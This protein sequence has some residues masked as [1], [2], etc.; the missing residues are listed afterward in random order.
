MALF[1]TAFCPPVEYFAIAAEY[2]CVSIEACEY[3]EKQTYRNRCRILTA[4]G[5]ESF[6]PPVIHGEDLYRTPVRDVRVDYSVDWVGRFEYALESAY[7][8]SPFFEYYRDQL[9]GILDSRPEGLLDLN[10]ALTRWIS[11]KLGVRFEAGLTEEYEPSVQDDFRGL[12]HPKKPLLR[13]PK[14]YWQVFRERFGFQGG[15]SSL[16]LLFCEGPSAIC[17]L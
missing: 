6:G 8:S 2:S 10:M 4:N 14:P 13:E 1:S 11:A 3:F 9:F 17:Y 5:V 16:D 12:I 15:L 7:D